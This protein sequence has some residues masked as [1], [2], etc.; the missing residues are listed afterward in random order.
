MTHNDL[1]GLKLIENDH[2]ERVI[3]IFRGV[4][5]DE[6]IERRVKVQITGPSASRIASRLRGIGFKATHQEGQAYTTTQIRYGV[7]GDKAAV[8]LAAHLKENVRMTPD[9]SLS[10]SNVR[11]ELAIEPPSITPG[12]RLVDAPQPIAQATATQAPP[13]PKALGVCGG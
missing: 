6:L 12:Y 7:G 4:G 2:N 9:P 13:P 8:L 3:D 11:L 1:A 5:W 10:G